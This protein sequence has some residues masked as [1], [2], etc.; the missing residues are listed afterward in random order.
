ML[1]KRYAIAPYIRYDLTVF[2]AFIQN[3]FRRVRNIVGLID[4]LS[5]FK[6]YG[7]RMLFTSDSGKLVYSTDKDGFSVA[8]HRDPVAQLFYLRHIVACENYRFATR[9]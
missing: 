3:V 4:L 9:F 2:F 8:K 1:F 6:R 5:V 7:Q